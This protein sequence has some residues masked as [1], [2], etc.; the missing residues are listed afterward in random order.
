MKSLLLKFIVSVLVVAGALIATD[1]TSK[2]N[3][4]APLPV[5]TF[6][7]TY[8][9]YRT[10]TSWMKK[11]T[12]AE[13]CTDTETIYGAKPKNPGTYPVLVYVHGTF[14]DWSNNQ[15]GRKFI[16]QAASLGFVAMAITYSSSSSMNEAGIQRHAYCM[17]NQSHSS[18]NAA[19]VMCSIQGAD[20]SK[21]LLVTGFSQ[22]A[23]IATVAKNYNQN[24]KAVWAIGLSAY[25][26][27]KE[28]IPTDT[29]PAPYGTRSLPNDKLVINM[30]E[31]SNLSTK[32]PLP[33]DIPSLK[34]MTGVNCGNSYD[35]VRSDGSGYYL[36]S[37]TEIKDKVA[38]HA[39]WMKVNSSWSKGLSFTFYPKTF[40]P[41]FNVTSTTKWSML[42]NLNWLRSQ[43]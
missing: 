6:K 22:G 7:T 2:A 26:Y 28:K 30:G 21:G 32:K 17:F 24:V 39:Y 31:A 35:C 14:A 40:D 15:E 29:L 19:S 11:P 38:D 18:K 1:I 8:K 42:T 16:E 34:Q 36:V 33:V 20:C 27:P 3:Q 25:I 10:S 23:G 12:L 43:L 37:N 9:G 13:R 41:G 4:Q 5:E